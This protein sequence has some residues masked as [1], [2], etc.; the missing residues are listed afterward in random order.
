MKV[1]IGMECSGVIRRA[2]EALGHEAWSCDFKPAED[3]D[4]RHIQDDVFK[5]LPIVRPRLAIF[6]PDCTY[7]TVSGYHWCYKDPA[8]YP[9]TVCGAARLEAVTLAEADFMRC[10]NADVE[11][12]AVEN[13]IG[14]MSTRY[15]RYDQLIQPYNFGDDASKGTCLWLKGLAPLFPTLRLAGRKVEFPL[16][17]GK[18]VERWSN[19]TDS[20]QNRLGPGP[21]RSAD[22]ARTY[23]GPAAAFAA[24]WG[25]RA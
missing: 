11:L 4:R 16:G 10:V 20:G 18:I 13:P 8:K 14:I 2:F 9:K 12:I 22:R 23:P 3:G 17:S 6:H 5:A 25:G 24:Q 1:F 7:L 21:Q 19:Q 15:R